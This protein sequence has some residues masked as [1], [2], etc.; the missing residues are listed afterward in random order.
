MELP[1]FGHTRSLFVK[2]ALLVNSALL[3][4]PTFPAALAAVPIVA[5][6]VALAVALAA[7]QTASSPGDPAPGGQSSGQATGQASSPA[8]NQAL[9]QA[10]VQ[11][12][13][14]KPMSAAE[15]SARSVPESQ[16]GSARLTRRVCAPK[17]LGD[18]ERALAFYR[19][20]A[21]QSPQD[22][23]HPSANGS[24]ALGRR[25]Q[26]ADCAGRTGNR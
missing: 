13:T 10:T 5:V 26:D 6:A 3:A 23:D 11:P 24:G 18:W 19:I 17:K 21:D 20:A 15:R 8:T 14:T 7:A 1:L 9:R 2:L 12:S 4:K 25:R 22:N 16:E